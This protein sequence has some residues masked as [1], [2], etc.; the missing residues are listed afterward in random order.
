MQ[1]EWPECS[2]A[3]GLSMSENPRQALQDALAAEHLEHGV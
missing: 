2:L 1:L 3:G